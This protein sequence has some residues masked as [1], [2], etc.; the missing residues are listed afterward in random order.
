MESPTGGG[1]CPTCNPGSIIYDG[2]CLC[3]PAGGTVKPNGSSGSCLHWKSKY[4]LTKEIY[5][6]KKKRKHETLILY[7]QP[8][9]QVR[10][11]A[12]KFASTVFA[13]N[14][15]PSRYLLLLAAGDP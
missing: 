2:W 1:R 11:V 5:S 15:V 12:I 13:S 14:H 3:Q 10:Q 6:L 4:A 7:V 8:E 9:V